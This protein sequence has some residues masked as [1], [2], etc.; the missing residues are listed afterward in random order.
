MYNLTESII[1]TLHKSVPKYSIGRD[2]KGI[3]F[4]DADIEM[5]TT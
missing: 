1:F 2:T 5:C 4:I 3:H